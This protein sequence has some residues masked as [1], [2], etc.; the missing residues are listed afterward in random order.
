LNS[1]SG[2]NPAGSTVRRSV[3]VI[4]ILSSFGPFRQPFGCRRSGSDE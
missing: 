1:A 4:V 3:R 2:G